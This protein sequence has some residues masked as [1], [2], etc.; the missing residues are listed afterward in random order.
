M[1]GDNDHFQSF[2]FCATGT[3]L[4][5]S[6]MHG[7]IDNMDLCQQGDTIWAA[8]VPEDALC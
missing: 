2:S 7:N 1:Q 4:F 8:I 5:T 6:P 3:N